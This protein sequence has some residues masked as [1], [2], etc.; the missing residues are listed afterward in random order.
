MDIQINGKLASQ[1][2]LGN[3]LESAGFS[4]FTDQQSSLSYQ[5]VEQGK[6]QSL[7]ERGEFGFLELLKEVT[8]TVQFDNKI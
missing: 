4:P 2:D 5:I 3:L 8:G 1:R 7:A 6:I